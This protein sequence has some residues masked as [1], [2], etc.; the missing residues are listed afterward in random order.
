MKLI[1][2]YQSPNYDK[3]KNSDIKLI[4]IHYTALQNYSKALNY[5]CKKKNKVSSHYL[6]SQDG[7]IYSLVNE[8]YRAWHAGISYWKGNLDINSLSIGIELDFSYKYT[9]NKYSRSMILSL[10]KLLKELIN[11]YKI[12]IK[13]VL[14][15]SDIAPF[16]KKD[17]GYLF[18]WNKLFK[19]KLSFEPSKKYK[20]YIPMLDKWFETKNYNTDKKI[21]IFILSIIGYDTSKVLK[22]KTQLQILVKNYQ[23]KYLKKISGKIDNATIKHMK[24]HY[25]NLLL[26]KNLNN[27]ESI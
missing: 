5:L 21:V 12:D 1:H 6:I 18:P 7:S 23:I 9:N 16:R 14:G 20:R 4:I 10:Q 24:L 13:N 11:R 25:L 19:L 2:K 8:K 27:L 22:N 17:P 3:R 26:T 15:H